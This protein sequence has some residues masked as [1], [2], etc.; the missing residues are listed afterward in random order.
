MRD[1]LGKNE[2]STAAAAT[3]RKAVGVADPFSTARGGNSLLIL[4]P[5]YGPQMAGT[6]PRAALGTDPYTKAPVM[7]ADLSE[8][9]DRLLGIPDPEIAATILRSAAGVSMV[10]ADIDPDNTDP[11]DPLANLALSADKKL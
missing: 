7:S 11:S 5:S 9:L 10:A 3:T 4:E 8:Y 6:G 2:W 1:L